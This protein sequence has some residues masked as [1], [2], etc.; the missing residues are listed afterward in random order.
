MLP[1]SAPFCVALSIPFNSFNFLLSLLWHP[2]FS[3]CHYFF[4]VIFLHSLSIPCFI[5]F[6]FS[7][8]LLFL[9]I[10]L[11]E[12]QDCYYKSENYPYL[13]WK[14]SARKLPVDP[15][16]DTQMFFSCQLA[17]NTFGEQMGPQGLWIYKLPTNFLVLMGEWHTVLWE[18]HCCPSHL[19]L[20]NKCKGRCLSE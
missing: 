5:P 19:A 11:L 16:A 20:G 9:T 17:V 14:T 18:R 7:A 8:P 6:P 15:T 10:R 4:L 13:F 3:P 1:T 2:S 12:D